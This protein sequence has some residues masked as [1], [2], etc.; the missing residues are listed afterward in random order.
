MIECSMLPLPP[1]PRRTSLPHTLLPYSS[2]SP[3]QPSASTRAGD[4]G[5]LPSSTGREARVQTMAGCCRSSAHPAGRVSRGEAVAGGALPFMLS[6]NCA[7]LL[8]EAH[9]M[10]R[11]TKASRLGLMTCLLA[12]GKGGVGGH[13]QVCF[14]GL[15]P[16]KPKV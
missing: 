6:V 7:R 3:S 10:S 2:S 5:A 15:P 11:T 16:K 1:P 8:T 13:H 9:S 12:G 4:S 14:G